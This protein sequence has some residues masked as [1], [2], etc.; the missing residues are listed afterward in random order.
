MLRGA[1]HLLLRNKDVGIFTDL[2]VNDNGTLVNVL[3]LAGGS[4]TLEVQ[5]QTNTAD[6][7]LLKMTVS[8]LSD[9]LGLLELR[10][11]ALEAATTPSELLQQLLVRISHLENVTIM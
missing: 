3:D 10:V 2:Y 5:V 4:S 9:Q 1:E 6:I 7:E 11:R 8:A